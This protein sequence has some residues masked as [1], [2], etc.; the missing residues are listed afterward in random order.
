MMTT[1]HTFKLMELLG[2]D[3]PDL[4]KRLD[5][6]QEAVWARGGIISRVEWL[7]NGS[8]PM[9]LVGYELPIFELKGSEPSPGGAGTN[10]GRGK[11]HLLRRAAIGH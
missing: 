7:S 11:G 5:R 1:A 6:F 2:H 4:E 10:K 9:A 3:T 8:A